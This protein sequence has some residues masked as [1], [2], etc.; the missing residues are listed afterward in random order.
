MEIVL[1]NV[2]ITFSKKIKIAKDVMNHAKLVKKVK[3][4]VQ[5]AMKVNI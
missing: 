3:I 4:I 5:N 1:K 2:Q